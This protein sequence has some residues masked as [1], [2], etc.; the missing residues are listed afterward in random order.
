M[1]PQLCLASTLRRLE[2]RYADCALMQRAGL[3]AAEFALNVRVD[4]AGPVLVLAGPGNNG[5]DAI[6]AARVLR[7]RQIEVC[8]VLAGDPDRLPPDAAAAY[9]RFCAAGG[10]TLS[11]IP[12]QPRWCL[13]ID[14]L[15]GIGL[16]RAP[17]ASIVALIQSANALAQRECCPLL[18]LDCPSGLN[19]DTGSVPG[20]VIAATH[21]LTFISGKPGLL[22]A[23][24]PD[25]CGEIHLATL[26]IA[27]D[28]ETPA[29]GSVITTT[30]F[31]DRLTPRRRNS[32][33]GSFGSVGML[34]GSHS[35]V[36]AALLAGRAALKLGAG[37]VYLGLLTP[38]APTVDPLQPELM[39]RAVDT[40]FEA[41]LQTLVCGPGLGQTGEAI[42]Y[43]NQALESSLPLVLDADA[44]NLL[45][46]DGHLAGNLLNRAA[47][48]ILTPHPAEAARLLACSVSD[49]QQDRILSAIELARRFASPVALKGC[50]TVIA[51]VDGRWWINTTGHPGMATAGMGD[52][53]C[54]LIAALLAQGWPAEQ[55]LLAAVH[56]H[57]A[58]ADHLWHHGVGP[59]GLTAGE[60]IDAARAVFNAWIAGHAWG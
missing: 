55:A 29:D 58:A 27:P 23:D 10:E 12:P 14:G 18:A 11:A 1:T 42:Q 16:S 33:K 51:T 34:G 2:Q 44:L 35:M 15:F 7:E 20:A 31:A 5:G 24:G 46:V 19:A 30:L 50:G 41:D 26:D 52:V 49:I 21:T 45:A 13:I 4:R 56:L 39:L 59:I 43:V 3:A 53:L 22:T 9:A 6:E 8:V 36:G 28:A 40:L 32:H 60:I 57:G 54:G 25:H 48:A 37:R 47:P 17:D 38:D